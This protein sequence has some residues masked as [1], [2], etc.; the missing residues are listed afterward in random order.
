[1]KVP[2]FIT[3]I[4]AV[5]LLVV[6]GI[7]RHA[8]GQVQKPNKEKPRIAVLPF[9]DTNKQAREEGYG[10]ALSG[11]LS[12]KLINDA[13]FRV[14]E[15]SEIERIMK[16]QAFQ[17]SGAVNAETAKQ[18]GE[19]YAVDF[20]LFGTMAKFGSLI[21]TDIRLVDTETGEAILAAN[22]SAPSETAARNMVQDLARKVENRY[23]QK[24]RPV[25]PLPVPPQRPASTT[26]PATPP[27]AI[28]P[29]STEGMV[30]I[31]GG[32]FVMGSEDSRAQWNEK[33]AHTVYVDAFYMDATEVTRRQYQ[34]F[35]EATG[36]RKP[37]Y[38]NDSRFNKPDMPVVGVTWED[39]TAYAAWAGKRLPTEAEWEFAARGGLVG[40]KFPWG[41]ASAQGKAWFGKPAQ[42]G[43]P[44][45]VGSFEPNGYGLFDM[46]GNVAEWCADWYRDDAYRDA[47]AN[48]PTG[49]GRTSLKV[50]RG[51]SWYEDSYYLR[52]SARKS[53]GPTSYSSS[54]GFRCAMSAR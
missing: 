36:R 12:T 2:R 20:L 23:R 40:Q 31:P 8:T 37:H 24:L 30:F 26:P 34:Q 28:Q 44:T 15:R 48:N 19:L 52:C 16:E 43:T 9:V 4:I 3:L 42:T 21:E 54:V 18:I 45:T 32:Q 5:Q 41:N 13:V 50:V 14:V 11:M 27:P 7:S 33:P 6:A 29:G 47:V 17:L 35:L 46:A 22:A 53:M 39:A 10:E 51:G 25:T 49:P 38:W 1:M